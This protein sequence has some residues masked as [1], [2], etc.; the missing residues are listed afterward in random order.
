MNA[1]AG[2]WWEARSDFCL[3]ALVARN[4]DEVVRE[5]RRMPERP[6]SPF[7]FDWA[8]ALLRAWT[9]EWDA[10]AKRVGVAWEKPPLEPCDQENFLCIYHEGR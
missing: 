6:G 7:V 9:E 10:V 3:M 8:E 5:L 1:A 4:P 2:E